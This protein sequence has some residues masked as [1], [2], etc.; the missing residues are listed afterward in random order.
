M[1]K[2]EKQ[3]TKT[4][5]S[6]SLF[7]WEKYFEY[8]TWKYLCAL[9]S[10]LMEMNYF[11]SDLRKSGENDLSNVSKVPVP[12]VGNKTFLRLGYSLLAE[13]PFALLRARLFLSH[14]HWLSLKI[15]TVL[16]VILC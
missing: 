5:H 6:A 14:S 10:S 16:F 3:I 15:H 2:M 4:L 11:D 1:T 7:L 12:N 9:V 13:H 8:S